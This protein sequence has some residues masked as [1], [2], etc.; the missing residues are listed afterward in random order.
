MCGIFLSCVSVVVG[1]RQQWS[2]REDVGVDA[3]ADVAVAEVATRRCTRSNVRVI[4]CITSI[5]PGVSF[6]MT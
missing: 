6:W 2:Q 4:T 3:Y 5:F 1:S